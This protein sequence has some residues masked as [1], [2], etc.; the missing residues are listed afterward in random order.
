MNRSYSNISLLA[1]FLLLLVSYKLSSQDFN[2]VGGVSLADDTIPPHPSAILDVRSV[3]KGVIIPQMT[4]AE[5]DQIVGPAEGLM[6]YVIDTTELAGVWYF[7][8]LFGWQQLKFRKAY[9]PMGSII[10]YN[11]P[12]S[13]YF[14]DAGIGIV[15]ST[16][17]WHICNGN[18][19]TPDLRDM[20]V[21]AYSP[22]LNDYKSYG[23]NTNNAKNT[24]KLGPDSLPRHNHTIPDVNVSQTFTHTH[25]LKTTNGSDAYNDSH[26]FEY[27]DDGRGRPGFDYQREAKS[28]KSK[29]FLFENS[30]LHLATRENLTNIPG[31]IS[32]S[33]GEAGSTNSEAFD[34]RPAYYT[35]V[36]IMR[37]SS[38]Y[39]QFKTITNP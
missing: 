30:G 14:S 35:L 24:Y 32:I 1:L 16:L 31:Q 33:F 6:V 9:Y 13:G 10:M 18:N 19:G 7:E 5:R 39:T 11:G 20:F 36:Y 38:P 15:E 2:V 29:E 12:I 17:G 8:T 22:T 21:V 23:A 37:T 26:K 34:N 25:Q 28:K 3:S 27:I 4:A